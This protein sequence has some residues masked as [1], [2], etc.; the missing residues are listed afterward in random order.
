MIET[1]IPIILAAAR[2]SRF[3]EEN[4]L[5]YNIEGRSI[6]DNTLDPFLHFFKTI[7]IVLGYDSNNMKNYLEKKDSKIKIM[8]NTNWEKGGMSSSIKAG[9]KMVSEE[10]DC[11][12]IFIHPGDIPF[13]TIKDLK[14][15][16]QKVKEHDYKN[17]VIP[18]HEKRKGHPIYIPKRKFSE[19]FTISEEAQ[20]LREIVKNNIQDIIYVEAGKGILKDIDKKSDLP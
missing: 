2:G 3:G 9:L 20:G 16:V 12:G 13:V 15:V 18:K 4:K 19:I 10:F 7:V 17:I 11:L 5:S 8:V 6:I 14:T 1:I